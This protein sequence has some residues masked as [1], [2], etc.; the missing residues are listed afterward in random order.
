MPFAS[1]CD[2]QFAF[3]IYKPKHA[4][5]SQAVARVQ[6][7]FAF[8]RGTV[9]RMQK[10]ERYGFDCQITEFERHGHDVF[11]FFTHPDDTTAAEFH[12]SFA[13]IL[14]RFDTIVE[15]M[16][17]ANLR[18]ILAARVQI[19]IHL[20][21]ASC[22]KSFGLV[23]VE[24]SKTSADVEPVLFLDLRNNGLDRFHFSLVGCTAADH[25][26]IGLALSLCCESGTV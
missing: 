4:Q 26:A 7:L 6:I 17:R 25:D 22:L 10:V 13:N 1:A 8:Q 18:I 21:H 24:Q 2:S 5:R 14:E 12:A 3:G 9:D 23:L 15:G 16:R 19:M 20:V 11:V